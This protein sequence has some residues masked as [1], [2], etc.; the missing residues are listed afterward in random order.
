MNK[1]TVK[2]IDRGIIYP[3][4][5]KR[6]PFTGT[7]ALMIMMSSELTYLARTA[8]AHEVS[9]NDRDLY[10]LY[11]TVDKSGMPLTLS[12]PF[13]GAP[14]AVIAME[15]L[16]ALGAKRIWALGWCGS[17]Q[18][19]L[20]TGHIVIPTDAVSEE[21]TSEHYPISGPLKS[22]SRL[23]H[24]LEKALIQQDMPFSKGKIWTTDAL[25]RETPKKVR[26]HQANGV[27]AVEMEI[28][29]LMTLALYRSVS[30]A[31]LLVVSDELFDLKWRPGFSSLLL[32]KNTHTAG[33]ILKD[34]ATS[35][36]KKTL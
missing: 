18:H 6:E 3:V 24:M 29:A 21:G 12:G 27:L 4:K 8:N 11:Q 33:K 10:Q 25:Y 7:D 20:R 19:N 15:K 26:E 22:D 30:M 9:F 23:N 13:L 5:G 14:L 2:D 36:N 16:I 1:K 35:L 28:S 31:A 17:L 34:L 32:K